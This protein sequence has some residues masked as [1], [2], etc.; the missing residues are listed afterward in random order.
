MSA[1]DI[2]T[3]T[4]CVRRTITGE[5]P[6]FEQARRI[7]EAGGAKLAEPVYTDKVSRTAT[8]PQGDEPAI[9]PKLDELCRGHSN[10]TVSEPFY[11]P[12]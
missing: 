1:A 4:R 2:L 12:F 11:M 9:L 3:G 8:L 10:A 5:Y 7:L 6:L